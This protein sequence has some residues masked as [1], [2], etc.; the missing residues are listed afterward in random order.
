[1]K[2]IKTENANWVYK[3]DPKNGVR[4]LSCEVYFSDDGMSQVAV[5]SVW[6][7]TDEERER[8]V[9]GA[10]IRMTLFTQYRIPPSMLEVV[11]LRAT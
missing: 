9:M 2:P 10:N 6:E 1:M 3:G 4:D 5:A 7:P 11:D 8:I